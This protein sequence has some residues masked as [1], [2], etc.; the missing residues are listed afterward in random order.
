M[1]PSSEGLF[2]QAILQS[3][4]ALMDLP[5]GALVPGLPTLPWFGWTD[6]RALEQ[7]GAAAAER[8]GCTDPVTALACLGALPVEDL[9]AEAAPFQ[10]YAYGNALLPD[11][12]ITAMREGRFHR[13][14][15]LSGATRDEHR[16]F[17]GFFYDL[18]GQPVTPEGYRPL[19][20]AAFGDRAGDVEARYPLSDHPSPSV[21]WAAVLTDRMW[22]RATWQQNRWFARHVPTFAYEFAD[23]DAPTDLPFPPDFPPGAFHAADVPYLFRDATFDPLLSDAQRALSEQMIRYWAQFARSGD[24]NAE[25]L[26][27]WDA[28]DPDAAMPYVQALAPDPEGT[29]FVDYAAVHRLAFWSELP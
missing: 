14:P 10:P 12:P 9:F 3:G 7:T 25:G 11:D 17:V 18:A 21:A 23:R 1:A 4:F 26:P 16:T 15:I 27:A 22:A 8:L 6:A 20:D 2:E 29:G 19:L 5:A 24:P 28:F 13:V